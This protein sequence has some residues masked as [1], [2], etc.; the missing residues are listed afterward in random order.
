MA[1][2]K[3]FSGDLPEITNEIIQYFRN[4]FSTLHSCILVNRLWCR[5]TIPLLWENPFSLQNSK[6][7]R[8]IELYLYNLNDDD[9]TQLNEYGI[10][11]NL[12]PSNTLFN[13]PSFIQHLDTRKISDSIE[14]W[15]AAVR[16]SSTIQD[17]LFIYSVQKNLYLKY[18]KL[19]YK[20]LLQ[21]I[22]ENEVN[23]H[24]INVKVFTDE[25]REYFNVTFALVSQNP[26]FVC[27]I[28]NLALHI[29]PTTENI[30]TFIQFFYSN[31]NSISSLNLLFPS[32]CHS[33][34]EKHLSLIVDSQQNLKKI[35][36]CFIKLPLYHSLLSLKNSNCT[37]TLRTII[38]YFIDFKNIKIL[39]EVFE[40]LNVLESI[41]I[42]YCYSLDSNFIQQVINITKPF[43]LKSLIIDKPLLFDL[44][45]L[46]LQKSGNYLE[47]LRIEPEDESKQQLLSLIIKYCKKIKFL[48][49]YDFDNQEGINLAI[50]LI[51]H[52]KNHLNYL[53]ID[54]V[55]FYETEINLFSSMVLQNLGQ[56]LPTKL[57]YLSLSLE[58]N[59]SDFEIF[60]KNSQNT[61]IKTL[62]IK[63]IR[64]GKR[65]EEEKM[66]IL[67]FIKEYIMKKKR[68]EYFGFLEYFFAQIPTN[69]DDLY[70]LKN[71]VKEFKLYNIT[72]QYYNT[73]II[74]IYK[75]INEMY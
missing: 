42:L 64:Y 6:N 30:T 36:L 15:A 43:K 1:C 50:H 10:N 47:N 70:S 39:N 33:K 14:R 38:F 54:F 71:E 41:H 52:I 2:T 21:I 53:T 22:I 45:Q 67:P 40:Q 46:L 73:L 18:K 7:Y 16:T 32:N 55:L 13:Y 34:T 74:D 65:N 31:C 49:L 3:I 63:N 75:F 57:E 27:N 61:F 62:L 11:N 37:N 19:I 12:L 28:K 20:L 9:K 59:T 72:I 60:L 56:M 51:E 17:Q 44:L 48:R 68:T 24:T 66:N 4:D 58:I 69:V 29:V 23:M 5:L 35:S 8:Y 26:N 25:D